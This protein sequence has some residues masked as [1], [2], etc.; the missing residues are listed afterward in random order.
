MA[1]RVEAI[2]EPSLLV[3]ARLNAGVMVDAAAKSAGVTPERVESW[4]RGEK[5]PTVNQSSACVRSMK[6]CTSFA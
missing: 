2:V 6:G 1:E 5:R 3:W 4:E